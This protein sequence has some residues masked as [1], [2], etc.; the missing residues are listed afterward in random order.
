[1]LKDQSNQIDVPTKIKE[2]QAKVES[3]GKEKYPRAVPVIKQNLKYKPMEQ[4]TKAPHF[5]K[6]VPTV[7]TDGPNFDYN[8]HDYELNEKDKKFLAELNGKI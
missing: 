4:V 3:M 2:A 6:Y 8:H 1:M 5:L 7:F